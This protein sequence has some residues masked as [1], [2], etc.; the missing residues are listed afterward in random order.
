MG[1]FDWIRGDAPPQVQADEAPAPDAAKPERGSFFTTD[2]ETDG[3]T[4]YERTQRL[5]Q[6]I[7]PRTVADTFVFNPA[8][9]KDSKDLRTFAQ[10]ASNYEDGLKAV[11]TLGNSGVPDAQANWYASQSFIGYQMCALLAQHW[12]V[13]KACLV[14]ARDAVRK[15][16][17]IT[18]NDGT[19]AD[20][21]VMA[22]IESANKRH[23]LTKNL[24]EFVKMG[25]VF[26]I[27]VAI[28]IVESDDPDYYSKP[29]NPDSITPGSYRG[30]SQVDP[31][32]CVP[33]LTS[34]TASN[35]AALDFYE[36][37]YWIINSRRYHRSHLVIMRGP[38][39]ADIFKPSYLYGGLSIPQMIY[40]RVYAAERTANEAPQLA[41]TKRA[42]VFYT[43][44]A[45]ALAN[46]QK[47]EERLS[48]WARFRDNFGVKVADIDDKVEQHDTSLADLDA[49]IMTQYQIVA[50]ACNIPATKLLG[51]T[52]KGF[53]S[54]G[55][56]EEDSYHEELE[57]IQT[58]DMEPLIDR[59]TLCVIRSEIAP[60]FGIAPFPASVVW[61]PLDSLSSKELAEINNIKANTAKIY[62]VDIGAVDGVEVR[63][64][65][66][67]DENS[68]Y[69]GLGTIENGDLDDGEEAEA[70]GQA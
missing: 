52:P 12:L 27:R 36:P 59:H 1:L 39:V 7:F 19:Q 46:Q 34:A 21:A 28:C 62:A 20:P 48:I 15:G 38:E 25:R 67:A 33:E 51:T 53:N 47:F 17:K 68:G 66:I 57:S 61:E 18:I 60:R 64:H 40:E 3:L 42:M 16:F 63:D 43:D 2:M 24:V 44:A 10:D 56:Y 49:V 69:S 55:G 26:G 14:P 23:K 22:A 6:R 31:Y 58:S 4:R 41:L 9:G 50:A 70:N 5:Q 37:T 29:F 65:L 13:N 30:I 32:W 8:A 11:Y 54:S 45:K 35:P